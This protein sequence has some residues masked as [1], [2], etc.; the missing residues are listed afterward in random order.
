VESSYYLLLHANR[1]STANNPVAN[2]GNFREV[3][4]TVG[5][6]GLTVAL[7]SIYFIVL[8][9]IMQFKKTKWLV[10]SGIIA[11]AMLVVSIVIGSIMGGVSLSRYSHWF[12]NDPNSTA[13]D[14]GI[15]FF[16]SSQFFTMLGSMIAI[17]VLS[18]A[19]MVIMCM[20]NKN[21]ADATDN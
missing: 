19:I 10:V 3:L 5:A 9:I 18:T 11:Y 12:G 14:T 13:G 20:L 4:L 8:G 17:L 21:K 7:V 6:V 1:S 16:T 2:T 15:D